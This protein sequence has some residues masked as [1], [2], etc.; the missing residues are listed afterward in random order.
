MST[1]EPP[2]NHSLIELIRLKK[3]KIDIRL[4]GSE[5]SKAKAALITGTKLLIKD[6]STT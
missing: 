3:N 6:N 5:F 2:V 4:I 1:S